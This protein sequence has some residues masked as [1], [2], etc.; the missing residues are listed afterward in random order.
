[1]ATFEE[2]TD[3]IATVLKNGE[4]DIIDGLLKGNVLVI[5]A[6]PFP[7][8]HDQP[9]F[10][11]WDGVT[12]ADYGNVSNDGSLTH[13]EIDGWGD[14]IVEAR[15]AYS[16]AQETAASEVVKLAWNIMYLM[17]QHAQTDTWQGLLF[18]SCAVVP[19]ESEPNVWYLSA[20]M[21]FSVRYTMIF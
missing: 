8:P 3:A 11:Y 20:Q 15:T 16:S 18:R 17:A 1:V 13:G 6:R 4:P 10:V 21:R 7:S 12:D 19:V 5:A 14:W 2:I 9:I